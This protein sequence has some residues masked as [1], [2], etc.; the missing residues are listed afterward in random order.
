MK[1]SWSMQLFIF[2][3]VN[4]D[5]KCHNLYGMLLLFNVGFTI[6][7]QVLRLYPCCCYRRITFTSSTFNFWFIADIVAIEQR[8]RINCL[9][10][11][12]NQTEDQSM[13]KTLISVILSLSI[14]FLYYIYILCLFIM[15]FN[16]SVRVIFHFVIP[17]FTQSSIC[18]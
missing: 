9:T 3:I 13:N 1:K 7:L 11:T 12:L 5:N 10:W 8:Q 6:T 18:V 17:P 15:F 14:N 16:L 2:N 4:I